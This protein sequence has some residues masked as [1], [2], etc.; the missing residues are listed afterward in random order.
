MYQ[1]DLKMLCAAR[2]QTLRLVDG[3]SQ[4][5]AEFSP[6]PG[7]WSVAEVLDHLI[8]ADQLYRD[9]FS[10]LIALQTAGKKAEIRSDS[11]EIN[12]SIL[13]IPPEVLP[14]LE[15]PLTAFNRFV[16]S[17]IREKV[18]Q[19]R[20]MPAQT[21]SVAKPRPGRQLDQERTELA[22]SLEQTKNLFESNPTLN[23]R[24]MLFS[25]PL[26]G[27]ND[28]LKMIRILALHEHRHQSQ[29]RGILGSRGFP[30]RN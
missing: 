25:H 10:E 15:L 21:P 20:V 3:L 23:Y 19:Y 24:E 29:I 1:D 7:K 8:L 11:S 9:K 4:S 14:F 30:E 27:K 13:F 26:M 22:D 12:T 17:F 18:T 28:I 16:P 2:R 6:A 5:Q